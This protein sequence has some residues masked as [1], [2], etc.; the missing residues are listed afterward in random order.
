MG[1]GDEALL[2]VLRDLNG[3]LRAEWMDLRAQE[4]ELLSNKAKRTGGRI[5]PRAFRWVPNDP[6]RVAHGSHSAGLTY[7]IDESEG[8]PS[9]G[10]TAEQAQLALARAA[11]SW[12]AVPCLGSAPER[13][14]DLGGDPDLFDAVFGYGE[15]GVPAA[16]VTF[17][18]FLPSGFFDLVA[19]PGGDVIASAVTFIFV[20]RHGDPTDLDGDGYLDAA[21]TEIYFND[22]FLWST[23]EVP[24]TMDVESV[25][26]HE[27][28]HAL[29]IGHV[30]PPA[31][32]VMN[33]VYAGTRRELQPLDQANLCVAR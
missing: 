3:T 33:P 27:L 20:D 13:R 30:E 12:G 25:A 9:A 4:I 11:G 23:E 29:G 31:E 21:A 15:L 14:P 32:A 2:A 19:P 24:G 7:L 26:L 17:A 18:G 8:V 1:E 6:R 22:R 5:Q 10:V 28:G 16:D